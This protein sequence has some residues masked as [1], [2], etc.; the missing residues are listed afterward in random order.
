MTSPTTASEPCVLV[1]GAV[2]QVFHDLAAHTNTPIEVMFAGYLDWI[3]SAP[4]KVDWKDACTLFARL[5]EVCEGKCDVS[6]GGELAVS[7]ERPGFAVIVGMLRLVASP[8]L[9]YR[10]VFKWAGNRLFPHIVVTYE[11]LPD[12][13]IRGVL[14]IPDNCEDSPN[15]FKINLGNFRALP[16]ALGLPPSIVEAEITER[17][18]SCLITPPPSL[19]LLSRLIRGARAVFSVRSALAEM[20]AQQEQLT[21]QFVELQKANETAHEH[22]RRAEAEMERAERALIVKSE[23]IATM[24]HEV[25]TPLNG[26]TGGIEL[27]RD[28]V[29]PDESELL[30]IVETSVSRLTQLLE[31]LLDFSDLS[32]GYFRLREENFGVR[33]FFERT[34]SMFSNACRRAGLDLEC[35]VDD[36]VP[37][38]VVADVTRLGQVVSALVDN[39]LKFTNV[40]GIFVSV[41]WTSTPEP[42]LWVRVRDTGPGIAEE[43]Q[44][45]I[46]LPFSQADSS[47]TR[48]A[49]G[50][51]LGLATCKRLAEAMHGSLEVDSVPGEGSTFTFSLRAREP[52]KPS[53]SD[54]ELESATRDADPT[55]RARR[56][57][58][59]EDEGQSDRLLQRTLAKAGYAVDATVDASE[60]VR[61]AESVEYDIILMDKARPDADGL[62][63]T[64]S[65]RRGGKSRGT[66]IIAV[67]AD[68]SMR[69]QTA[70]EHAGMNDFVAKPL[71]EAGLLEKI[72][73]WRGRKFVQQALSPAAARPLDNALFAGKTA[74]IAEDDP[75]NCQVLARMLHRLGF[76]VSKAENGLR[77]WQLV[78]ER[79]FDVVLMDCEMPVMDGRAATRKIRVLDETR[80]SVPIIAVTAYASPEDE[81]RCM[82]AGMDAFLAKPV[83]AEALRRALEQTVGASPAEDG[84]LKAAAGGRFSSPRQLRS[85]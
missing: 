29:D 33:R 74:L 62:A 51:G 77:A 78:S 22:R 53:E 57:L 60:A 9:L 7:S 50:T 49:G 79:P 68:T 5:D 67:S 34:T 38:Q 36:N 84:E 2:L 23:F 37:D 24:S 12:G 40:G 17:Q 46:F 16:R 52:A 54:L 43:D 8:T 14:R 76:T 66:P 15:F 20:S 65:I 70:C 1:D 13:R 18:L 73:F 83:S 19:T 27:L 80:S 6:V 32:S 61:A 21:R 82:D 10:L 56:V 64:R 35:Q 85:D 59:V 63:A 25:R 58:V 48:E 42:T 3:E 39:A 41:D 44:A 72:S 26:I 28:A 71:S 75:V 45:Q 47:A 11:E 81:A 30:E 31:A 55:Q 69:D 4:K